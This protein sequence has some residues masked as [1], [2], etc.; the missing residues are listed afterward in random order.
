MITLIT[1]P[2]ANPER[3]DE[4]ITHE[5]GHNWFMSMLG[6]NERMHTWQDEGLNSYFENRY[7]AEKYR[8]NSIFGE[9]IPANLKKL[10]TEEFQRLIY[11][12]MKQIPMNSKIDQPAA[13]FPTSEDYAITSYYKASMWMYGLEAKYGRKLVDE[14][15]QLYFKKWH[16]KHV[17][18][19]DLQKAFEEVTG[20]NLDHYFNKLNAEGTL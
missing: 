6:S 9:S 10:P 14:A 7:M 4:V 16:G 20:D 2:D 13:N 15:F 19:K 8:S 17:S 3:L 1:S 12:A 11:N 18:P 5:V